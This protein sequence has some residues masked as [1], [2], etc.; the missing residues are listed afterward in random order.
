MEG[1]KLFIITFDKTG[2]GCVIKIKLEHF[3]SAGEISI[4]DESQSKISEAAGGPDSWGDTDEDSET[5][6]PKRKVGFRLI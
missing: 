2:V 1:K 3:S 4:A 6:D 5:I